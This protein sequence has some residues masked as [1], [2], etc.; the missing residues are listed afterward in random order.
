MKKCL[1]VALSVL[2]VSVVSV[3]MAS[4]S[5]YATDGM[6]LEGY[7]PIATGMGGAS[8]AYDNGTAAMMNNPA[9]LGLMP[10]GNRLDV[11]LGY[12]GPHI[13]ASAP[14]QP[15]AKSSRYD[16]FL[17]AGHWM[18]PEV[19]PLFLWRRRVCA[20]RY[21]A[22]YDANSFLAAGSG[23]KVRSEL[24]VGR[25]LIPFA[26]EVNKNLS[27]GATVDYVWATLDLKMALTGAQFL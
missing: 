15:D 9:T 7:G 23:E 11:A 19:R 13:T 12:L 5:V 27:L 14:G 25:L 4:T 2:F 21:G 10:Q 6:N 17:D 24:G 16:T 1:S 3:F 26:Y 20:G 22:E 18:G 8:M